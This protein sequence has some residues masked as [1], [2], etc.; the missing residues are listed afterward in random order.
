MTPSIFNYGKINSVSASSFEALPRILGFISIE[1]QL[2]S[3]QGRGGFQ[4]YGETIV[5]YY[6]SMDTSYCAELI[7]ILRMTEYWIMANKSVYNVL[8]F[9]YVV[10]VIH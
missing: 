4:M 6:M 1:N 5:M 10:N 8:S 7:R 2:K 9:Y 3:L